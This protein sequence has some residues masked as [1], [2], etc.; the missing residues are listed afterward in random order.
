M[1]KL[2]NFKHKVQK[3]TSFIILCINQ[4]ITRQQLKHSNNFMIIQKNNTEIKINKK[5]DN[6]LRFNVIVVH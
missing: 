6:C 1:N 3:T 4:N 2:R 5:C